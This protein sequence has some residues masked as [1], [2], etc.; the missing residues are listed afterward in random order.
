MMYCIFLVALLSIL[1]RQSW[2]TIICNWNFFP[3]TRHFKRLH[4]VPFNKI[5]IR[6]FRPGNLSVG[7]LTPRI[8]PLLIRLQEFQLLVGKVLL[9]RC[10]ILPSVALEGI[11][12]S[13]IT[14]VPCKRNPQ[15]FLRCNTYRMHTKSE[16]LL[17]VNTVV[18][19]TGCQCNSTTTL[20]HLTLMKK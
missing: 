11:Y 20:M 1:A 14:L 8:T 17:D 10:C 5:A 15:N 16:K 19:L 7:T 3:I 4:L 9:Q 13:T 18:T 2:I 6:V 12:L